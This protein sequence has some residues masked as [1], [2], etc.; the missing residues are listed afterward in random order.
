LMN[1]SG[2]L[3]FANRRLTLAAWHPIE[4]NSLP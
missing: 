3:L 4:Q 2:R 1:N